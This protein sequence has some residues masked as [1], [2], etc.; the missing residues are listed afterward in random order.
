MRMRG[1]TPLR[2]YK[3]CHLPT[4]SSWFGDVWFPG[5]SLT[6]KQTPRL[7]LSLYISAVEWATASDFDCSCSTDSGFAAES[8]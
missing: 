8:G 1:V 3:Q 4:I 6:K 7:P 5:Y 2:N